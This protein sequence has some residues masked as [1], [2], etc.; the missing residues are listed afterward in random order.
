VI[1]VV[2]HGRTAANAAGLLLGR[3]DP[4][5][6]DVGRRQATALAGVCAE[7]DLAR[8]ITSP[9]ARCR[10]TAEVV[11]AARTRPAA[12][13]AAT[14]RGAVPVEVDE[15]WIELDYGELDGR[16]VG[17]VPPA[18]WAAWR[19]DAAWRPPGGES[20][21]DL[22]ARVRAACDLLV[23][24]AR[25]HDIVVVSHVSPIKAAVAWAL[26]VGDEAAWRMWVGPASITRIG[27]SG[28]VPSLRT[29]NEVA[30][31]V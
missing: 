13:V 31:L 14:R 20:L 8:V 1:V 30:H 21:A 27:V 17:E 22:G 11:A 16:P 6:D 24:A 4:V 12:G 25:E 23:D 2:R 19:A 18:T 26:G 9:L 29:F 5:L 3:A 7:L 15:R 28:P 10:Q